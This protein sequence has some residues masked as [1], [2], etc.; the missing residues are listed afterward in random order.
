MAFHPYKC[1]VLTITKKRNPIKFNYT[2]G[3]FLGV[4]YPVVDVD[5]ILHSNSLRMASLMTD[6]PFF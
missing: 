2:F 3:S 6:K 4:V 1:N 5:P